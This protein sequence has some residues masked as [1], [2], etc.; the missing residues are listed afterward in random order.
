MVVAIMVV[1]IMVVAI[2]VIVCGDTVESL[3]VRRHAQSDEHGKH[4]T[5]L[6]TLHYI[7]RTDKRAKKAR[8]KIIQ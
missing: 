7:G 6:D 1:A 4:I 8:I 5:P 3:S 2:M